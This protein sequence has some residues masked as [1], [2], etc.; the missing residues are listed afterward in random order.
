MTTT[1]F[2]ILSLTGLTGSSF[3]QGSWCN[4][5]QWQWRN[6]L[7]VFLTSTCWCQHWRSQQTRGPGW[8]C[9]GMFHIF[10]SPS[11]GQDCHSDEVLSWTSERSASCVMSSS[12][13]CL[14]VFCLTSSSSMTASY[15]EYFSFWPTGSHKDCSVL[16]C[17]ARVWTGENNPALWL[18]EFYKQALWLDAWQQ[19]W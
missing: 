2:D 7:L 8:K 9:T 11:K 13:S 18:V 10:W 3:I 16:R 14:P 15:S 4:D 6:H 1:S 19:S 17:R 5:G 12:S